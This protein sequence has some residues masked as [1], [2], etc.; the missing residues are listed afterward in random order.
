M[1]EIKAMNKI[2]FDFTGR[3]PAINTA[4]NMAMT[5]SQWIGPENGDCKIE[6]IV[7]KNA[8]RDIKRGN[9]IKQFIELLTPK[10]CY[11][12]LRS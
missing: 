6:D 3:K 9:E 7:Y 11:I 5:L 8:A 2:G 10:N 12:T 1:E 4:Q